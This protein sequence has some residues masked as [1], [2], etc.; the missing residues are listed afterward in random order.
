MR[1]STRASLPA[2]RRCR[3]RSNIDLRTAG[4]P[5]E[6]SNA[7]TGFDKVLPVAVGEHNAG[8]YGGLLGYDADRIAAL[9]SEG[10][11]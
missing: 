8:V 6:F 11:I 3:S 9:K 7:R 10:V 2:R 4:V 5:I 1:W